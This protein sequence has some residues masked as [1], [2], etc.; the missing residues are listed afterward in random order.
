MRVKLKSLEQ[1]IN[2]RNFRFCQTYGVW[3]NGTGYILSRMNKNFGKILEVNM[4]ERLFDKFDIF[5][6]EGYAYS[7]KWLEWI[8]DAST[9]FN[10]KDD[11]FRIEI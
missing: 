7:K 9:V 11:L 3:G 10:E 8:D 5:D 1:V 6:F 4:P 2:E